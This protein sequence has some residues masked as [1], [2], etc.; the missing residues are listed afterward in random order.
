MSYYSPMVFGRTSINRA[1]GEWDYT[2]N[3]ATAD[4]WSTT[5]SGNV[6]VDTGNTEIDFLWVRDASNDALG[7]DF[8]SLDDTA[9]ILRGYQWNFSSLNAQGSSPESFYGFSALDETNNSTV[10]QDTI[11]HYHR[12]LTSFKNYGISSADGAGFDRTGQDLQSWTPATST[13]YFWELI[14]TTATTCTDDVFSDSGFSTSVVDQ[15]DATIA[16]TTDSLQFA[17]FS[18]VT[19]GAEASSDITGTLQEVKFSDGVTVAPAA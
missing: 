8:T 14:R 10:S 3:F 13:D 2:S 9:W 4:G 7:R 17:K 19:L 11:F 18:N 15:S 1:P 12:F 16:S 6:S 5:D